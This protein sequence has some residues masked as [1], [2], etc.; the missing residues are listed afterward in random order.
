M[1]HWKLCEHVIILCTMSYTLFVHIAEILMSSSPESCWPDTVH[2]YVHTVFVQAWVKNNVF[3]WNRYKGTIGPN[4]WELW[5]L[6]DTPVSLCL[7]LQ[8]YLGLCNF[9]HVNPLQCKVCMVFLCYLHLPALVAGFP[10]SATTLSHQLPVYL[11]CTWTGVMNMINFTEHVDTSRVQ[12][13]GI[14]EHVHI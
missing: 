5:W 11:S 8:A 10:T 7:L 2:T 13:F 1:Q 6:F 4:L 3:T 12:S 14:I 9:Y